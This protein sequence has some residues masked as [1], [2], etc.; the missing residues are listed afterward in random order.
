MRRNLSSIDEG[1]ENRIEE[2]VE[3]F[4]EIKRRIEEGWERW[5]DYLF[6]IERDK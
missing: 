3:C 5:I 1:E 2:N 4:S 6:G